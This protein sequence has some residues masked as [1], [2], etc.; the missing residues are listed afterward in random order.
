MEVASSSSL[1]PGHRK[2]LRKAYLEKQRGAFKSKQRPSSLDFW[3]TLDHTHVVRG[4]CTCAA[5]RIGAPLSLQVYCRT[6]QFC[7]D[8][9]KKAAKATARKREREEEKGQRNS[10]NSSKSAG[11][12]CTKLYYYT[13]V[14]IILGKAALESCTNSLLQGASDFSRT[15]LWQ[16]LKIYSIRA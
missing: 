6:V 10:H 3:D 9:S 14:Y 15:T 4:I 13:R 16:N 7:T 12:F 2:N 11:A 1:W 8:W 5:R